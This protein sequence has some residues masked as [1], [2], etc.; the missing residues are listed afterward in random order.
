M[1]SERNTIEKGFLMN[2]VN[3]ND[4]IETDNT[5]DFS[6]AGEMG[7]IENS[8]GA[9]TDSSPEFTLTQK[10][11]ALITAV[12]AFVFVE[13]VMFKAAGFITTAFYI[14]VITSAVIF[15]KKHGFRFTKMTAFMAVVLYLFSIV[16]SI[17]DNL[18][19]KFLDSIFLFFYGAYFVCSSAD[20][21]QETERFLP[22]ALCKAIFEYPFCNFG[23][24]MLAAKSAV[25]NSKFT[26]NL[27]LI[28][29]GLVLAAVPTFVVAG[30]LSSADENIGNFLSEMMD[31][32]MS[33]DGATI[34]VHFLLSIPCGLYLYGM[35]YGSCRSDRNRL[36]YENCEAFQNGARFID[37][38]ILYTAVT[39]ILILYVMFFISQGSYFLSAFTGS[40]P[41]GY[42]YSEYARKGFFEL[43]AVTVINLFA[44]IIMSVFAKKGGK[45]K[46]GAMKAYIT[47]ISIFTIILIAVDISKM[48]MY[49]SEYGLTRLRF[50]TTWFMLLCAVIFALVIVRT[51]RPEMNIAGKLTGA[52][53]LMFGL[54]CFS[55]PDSLI[56]AYNIEMYNAG[57][58]DELDTNLLLDLSAD[59]ILTAYKK[60]AVSADDI[61]EYTD[62]PEDNAYEKMDIPSIMAGDIIQ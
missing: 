15:V 60:G 9:E 58:L 39:P 4:I 1:N 54:L 16:F 2:N 51:F 48:V 17:T 43:C 20:E 56:A 45:S 27:K 36:D 26:H 18:L 32:I 53:V 5:A 12:L 61:Y 10:I 33:E 22:F 29:I 14:A 8:G 62:I 11:F 38:I 37:N 49:I 35:F 52:F 34:F 31:G 47:V 28:I 59:G 21:S 19:I 41:D 13:F 42:S 7:I 30:L 6:E 23:M 46:T 25:R 57:Y 44:I 3:E 50:Y 24:Q 55:S 40:L